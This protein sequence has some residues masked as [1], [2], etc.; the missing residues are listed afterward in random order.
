MSEPTITQ[1]QIHA[2]D[3]VL[4]LLEEQSFQIL[5]ERNDHFADVIE[6]LYAD[7]TTSAR[8]LSQNA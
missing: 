6:K 4:Y 7:V 8:A 2:L 5:A 3:R 1:A